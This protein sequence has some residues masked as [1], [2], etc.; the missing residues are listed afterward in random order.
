YEVPETRPYWRR[1]MIAFGLTFSA[2]L[3]IALA[4]ALL[5]FGERI[6]DI[7]A[8]PIHMG[9]ILAV[10][11]PIIRWAATLALMVL[12]VRLVYRF[13]PNTRRDPSGAYAAVL[14]ALTVWILA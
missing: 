6:L 8:G 10:L 4:L 5:V 7:I 1:M 14:F 12:A 3:F 11:V 9:Y 2:G 13:A